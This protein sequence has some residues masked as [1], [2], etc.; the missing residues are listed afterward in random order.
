[1]PD[2]GIGKRILQLWRSDIWQAQA[3]ADRTPRGWFYAL[4]RVVSISC[5][6]FSETKTGSRAADLSFGSLLGLGP[7]SPPADPTEP[8][9]PTA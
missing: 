2:K 8:P 4:L 9:M 1:M 5:T 3:F 7:L 6:T